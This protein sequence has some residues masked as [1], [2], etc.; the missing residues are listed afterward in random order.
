[1]KNTLPS[2]WSSLSKMFDLHPCWWLTCLRMHSDFDASIEPRLVMKTY[3]LS[4]PRRP[5]TPTYSPMILRPGI[6]LSAKTPCPQPGSDDIRLHT[7]PASAHLYC[8]N[9]T[10][11]TVEACNGLEACNPAR[12]RVVDGIDPAL[13]E[14]AVSFTVFRERES[15]HSSSFLFSQHRFLS[16][17]FKKCEQKETKSD[18]TKGFS[19]SS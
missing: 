14:P 2:A 17:G 3:A 18:T 9:P 5:R 8:C 13:I 11:C 15:L 1:M 16:F 6:H 7:D 12:V 10:A 19:E 4:G